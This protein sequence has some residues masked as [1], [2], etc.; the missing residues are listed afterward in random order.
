MGTRNM[1]INETSIEVLKIERLDY[2]TKVE[3]WDK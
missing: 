1:Q 3:L 2:Y